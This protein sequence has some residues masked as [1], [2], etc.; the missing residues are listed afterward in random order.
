MA[1]GTPS[2]DAMTTNTGML[3]PILCVT[4]LIQ[5]FPTEERQAQVSSTN[6][7]NSMDLFLC[8]EGQQ[9]N[10]LLVLNIS[11]KNCGQGHDHQYLMYDTFESCFLC[12]LSLSLKS[13]QGKNLLVLNISKIKYGQVTLNYF[14]LS[15]QEVEFMY[16]SF[17]SNS[18]LR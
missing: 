4:P 3:L 5:I 6:S 11:K 10:N 15:L 7:I 9:G 2:L 12:Q 13:Q 1:L 14:F 8:L 18:F 17:Q 16:T